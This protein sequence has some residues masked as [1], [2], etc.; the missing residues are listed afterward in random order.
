M[1]NILIH[2]IPYYLLLYTRLELVVAHRRDT[3]SMS[4]LLVSMCANVVIKLVRNEN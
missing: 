1:N 4:S 3:M 2:I